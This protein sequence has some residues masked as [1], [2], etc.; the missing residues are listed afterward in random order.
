MLPQ[1]GAISSLPFDLRL[2]YYLKPLIPSWRASLAMIIPYLSVDSLQ[3]VG[4][5]EE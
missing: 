5:N 2:L 3:L 4:S 1:V